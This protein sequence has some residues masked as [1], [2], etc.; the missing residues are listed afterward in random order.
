MSVSNLNRRVVITG[1]GLVTPLGDTPADLWQALLE[2]RSGVSRLPE[3]SRDAGLPGYA[4]RAA[5]FTGVVDN[6]GPLEKDQQKAIRKGLKLMCRECQMGV[7]AAQ[8]ALSDAHRQSAGG[9]AYTPERRGCIFGT[10]YMLTLPDDFMAGVSRCAAEQG[11]FDFSR[12]GT[13][14]MSQ[15]TPLWLLKY[16]PNMPASHVAIFN[17]MRGPNNSLTH[18]EA[19]GNLAIGEAAFTIARGHAE[20]MVVGATGTRILPMNAIHAL[21]QEEVSCNGVDPAA[22]SRPFDRDRGGMVLGEGAA[23]IVL[24]ERASAQA[25]GARILGEVIGWSS[26]AVADRRGVADRRTALANV[27]R[28]VLRSTGRKPADVGHIHAHGVATRSGDAAEAAA[29]CDVLG[30]PDKQPPVTA[31]KSYFGNLGAGSGLVEL[32][33]SLL[34]VGE[35]QLPPI[36][37]YETPD[38]DCPIRAAKVGD[39]AGANFIN[40]SVTPQGQ[41]SAVLV[42]RASA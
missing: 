32:I 27:L 16:L 39:R 5:G 11:E 35:D 38:A 42:G 20:L 28:G 14:G 30:T 10:D 34:A 4:A 13:D 15:V 8:K 9:A 26:S 19:A 24:E 37:N 3:L 6:F 29:I 22:A 12:W 36:L 41:A 18:R 25:R 7:A 21:Q 2:K 31:A 17:D 40:L 23:A 33:V 1:L